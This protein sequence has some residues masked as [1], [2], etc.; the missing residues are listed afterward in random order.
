MMSEAFAVALG[1]KEPPRDWY[2]T[3]KQAEAGHLRHL[4]SRLQQM[5][6]RGMP[7]GYK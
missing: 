4:E 5:M 2:D 7:R 1:K 3:P 6:M